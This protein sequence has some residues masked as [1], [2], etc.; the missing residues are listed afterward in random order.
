[1]PLCAVPNVQSAKSVSTFDMYLERHSWNGAVRKGRS[2]APSQ[3]RIAGEGAEGAIPG[4]WQVLWKDG[5][6][7]GKLRKLIFEASTAT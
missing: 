4:L 1:M 7:N 2:S 3:I 6:G 5:G